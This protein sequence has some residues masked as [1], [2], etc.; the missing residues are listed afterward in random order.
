MALFESADNAIA[1]GI[2]LYNAI[3]LN[4]NPQET[5]GLP[6]V[7]IGVGIHSGMARIGIVGEE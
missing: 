6:Y 7:K 5:F 4:P 1:A 2:E 3:V